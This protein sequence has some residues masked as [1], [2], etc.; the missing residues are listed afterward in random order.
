MALL[1]DLLTEMGGITVGTIRVIHC[2]MET[3]H[4]IMKRKRPGLPEDM[5]IKSQDT[6]IQAKSQNFNVNL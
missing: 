2:E 1:Q 6:E 3:S 5:K 4:D